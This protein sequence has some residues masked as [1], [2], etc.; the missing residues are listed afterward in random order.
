M[1]F[2]IEILFAIIAIAGGIARYLNSF[3]NGEPF[4]FS[5]FLASAFVAGFS[6]MMFYYLGLTMDL[7]TPFL[8]MMAGTGGFFGE[9]TMKYIMEYITHKAGKDRIQQ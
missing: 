3:V 8:A 2:P 5:I 7:P 6:G 9:Q 4:K 1:K